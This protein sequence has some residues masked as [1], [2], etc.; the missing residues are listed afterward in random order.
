[1]KKIGIGYENF[2]RIL[3]EKCYYV[4]KTLLRKE[5]ISE[6]ERH[7]YL[8]HSDRISEMNKQA[9]REIVWGE[10]E[11]ERKEETDTFARSGG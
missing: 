10:L 3:D 7:D 9:F 4:D 11:W 1:M 5:I 2:K 6:Y 8:F